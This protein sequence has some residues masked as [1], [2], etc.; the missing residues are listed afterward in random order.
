MRLETL[1]D[2]EKDENSLTEAFEIFE[3]SVLWKGLKNCLPRFCVVWGFETT[4]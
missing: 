4:S 3:F 1:E 2:W